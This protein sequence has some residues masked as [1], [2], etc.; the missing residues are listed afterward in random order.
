MER[1]NA[2]MVKLLGH[3]ADDDDDEDG[4]GKTS[5]EKGEAQDMVCKIIIVIGCNDV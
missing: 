4:S 2:E 3:D 1:K 5:T